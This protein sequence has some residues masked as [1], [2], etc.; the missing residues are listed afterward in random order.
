MDRAKVGFSKVNA[1]TGIHSQTLERI[2]SKR[3]QKGHTHTY[4][5]GEKKIRL[6][7][8][9]RTKNKKTGKI[10]HPIKPLKIRRIRRTQ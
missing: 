6:N 3:L 8:V 2:T 7:D 4:E 9:Q 1:A 5:E 10:I